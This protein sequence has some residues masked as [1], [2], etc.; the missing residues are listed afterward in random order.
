LTEYLEAVRDVE[1]RIQKAEAQS[2]QQLPEI[3]QPQGIPAS[4]E[5]HAKLMF[6]LQ[7]LAYQTDL[8]R[9]ITFM[10]SREYS[11]RTYPEIGVP[12]A[13]H[14][15]SHHQ[16]DEDKLE[17]LTKI[18]VYHATL[19]AYYLEK[20]RST[21][22]GDGSLL[23]HIMIL[24]GGGISDSDRHSTENLPILLVGGGAGELRGGRHVRYPDT[25]M[26]NLHVAV[27]NKLG[28]P[29]QQFGERFLVST[30]ELDQLK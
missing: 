19:F 20:L 16:K 5:E 24:Y 27:M 9:M 14:P 8:T 29:T 2:D 17:K 22:D 13:H 15:I 11:G 12:D 4:F 25:P 1:R 21:P 10:V 18:S 6:D 23:D 28:V 3:D 7:V 26:A 30:G